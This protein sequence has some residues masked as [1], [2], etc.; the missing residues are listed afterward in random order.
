MAYVLCARTICYSLCRWKR[1][2]R[3]VAC[4]REKSHHQM[5]MQMLVTR[6]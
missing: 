1:M 3:C 2:C 4:G 5:S 6:K